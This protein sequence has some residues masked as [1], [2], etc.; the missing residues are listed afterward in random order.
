MSAPVLAVSGLTRHFGGL[1]ALSDVDINIAGGE[2]LGVIGPNG[3]GKSTLVALIA[4]ALNA[5]AGTIR[6]AGEDIT[7]RGPAERARAGIGR[8]HQI[9]RPFEGMSV[10]DNLMLAASNVPGAGS[11]RQRRAAC[12]TILDRTGLADAAHQSAGRLT[13][14]GRKRLEL[15]RAMALRPRLLML[16]E[17]GAG[18]VESAG[19]STIRA[20]RP[21]SRRP[22]RRPCTSSCPA[23]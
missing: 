2:V 22:H 4:G 3:A 12:L 15:A 23:S 7:R 21:R 11:T 10:L 14:L 17:I 19:R 20:A 16:D 13:L 18:L 8:T 9:P 6:L 1:M 5:S